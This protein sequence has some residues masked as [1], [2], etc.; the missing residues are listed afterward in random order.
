MT[1]RL[2]V[3][4]SLILSAASSTAAPLSL[5]EVLDSVRN[6]Y[7]PLLAALIQQDIA[8]GR[9]RQ[10]AGAFDTRLSASFGFRPI[11]FYDSTTSQVLVE[12]PFTQWGGS[13]YGG[14]RLS[15][16][17]LASYER[18]DRTSDLGEAV[19]GFRLPLLRDGDFDARRAN[20]G[21]AA[22]DRELADP[23]ILRQY[24]DILRGATVSYFTWVAAG[25]RL[26]VAEEILRIARDR[27]T[28]LAN[29]IEEGA[30]A[31][32]VQI[33]NQRL[34]VS[35]EIGVVNAQRFFEAATIELSLFY[36]RPETGEPIMPVRQRLPEVFPKP[37]KIDELQL[38]SDRGRAAFR[39]PEIRRIDLMIAKNGLDRRLARNNLKP[40]LDFAMELNQA[41]G[42]GTPSDI[43]QTELVGL[44]Q[45]SIPIG[46]NEAKG[47][48]EAID[49]EIRRLQED[50]RFAQDR[51]VADANDSYSAVMAA[52]NALAQASLN[53]ELAQRLEEAENDKFRDGAADLLALQ[54]R[55]QATFDA[56]VLEIDAI[57]SYFRALANYRAAIAADAPANLLPQGMK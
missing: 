55:E 36:R 33:D 21:K 51:I 13:V 30:V 46:Q 27:D 37:H 47:R 25:H 8:N 40:N 39:R 56:R 24:L 7:P 2:L 48:L 43:E 34:V 52:Y 17:F 10:A 53:V 11:N 12:Q 26:E 42:G 19:L 38:V 50:R 29:Q 32:I 57:A 22:I 18:K 3:L 14:Y 35:R 23:L 41:I 15:S 54:I 9:V 45:F 16:G 31:P 44:L 20:L 6:Q 5:D 4:T 49:G 1:R 28:A